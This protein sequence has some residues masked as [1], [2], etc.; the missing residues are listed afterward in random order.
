MQSNIA[1]LKLATLQSP[2]TSNPNTDTKEVVYESGMQHMD[3]ELSQGA[4][5]HDTSI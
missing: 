3:A 1:A 4:Q 5:E 2:P